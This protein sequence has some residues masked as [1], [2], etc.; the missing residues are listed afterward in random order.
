MAR[1]SRIVLAWAVGAVLVLAVVPQLLMR[2][3][4]GAVQT[5]G[6]APNLTTTAPQPPTNLSASFTCPRPGG[7]WD[8][9]VQWSPSPTPGTRGYQVMWATSANGSWQPG[10]PAGASFAQ[11]GMVPGSTR[12]Y[13]VLA[14]TTNS[15]DLPVASTALVSS[16]TTPKAAC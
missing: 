10:L 11:S 15:L 1:V 7:G 9:R 8:I 16:A 2:A 4:Q 14:V 12:W 3:E 5:A 13:Q 6:A